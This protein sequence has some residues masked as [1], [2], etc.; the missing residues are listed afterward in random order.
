MTASPPSFPLAEFLG[1]HT[2]QG[3]AGSA[4]ARLELGPAHLNPHGSAHGA[5]LFALV[6]TAMGA[7]TLSVLP[8]GQ[9]CASVD[10]ELRFC[11]AVREGEIVATTKVLQAGKRI[12]H[13]EAQIHDATGQL[14]AFGTGAFAVIGGG[15]ATVDATS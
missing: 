9:L 10:V 3:S 12:V 6:D 1:M 2:E 7:A 11:R 14:V 13:L 15:S 4:T 5:V 8:A